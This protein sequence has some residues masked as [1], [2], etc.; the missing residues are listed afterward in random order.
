MRQPGSPGKSSVR[1]SFRNSVKLI[2][3]SQISDDHN[4]AA[5]IEDPEDEFICIHIKD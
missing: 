3:K 4:G 2:D 1:E 5:W